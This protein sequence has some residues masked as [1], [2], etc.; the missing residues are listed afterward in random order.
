[1][2]RTTTPVASVATIL[3]A[4]LTVVA[5]LAV[6]VLLTP[7]AGLATHCYGAGGTSAA[8]TLCYDKKITGTTTDDTLNGTSGD[9]LWVGSDGDDTIYGKGGDD[10]IGRDVQELDWGYKPS[11]DPGADTYYGGDGED[12]LD[13][14]HDGYKDT[15]DCGA[16]GE[17]LASFEK[18]RA[19]SP[20]TTVSDNVNKKTCERLD[21]TDKEL[22]D[23][24]VKP[25]DNADVQCKTGTKRADELLGNNDPDILILDDMWGKGGN[26][27]LRG[28]RGFDG[29]E[30][31]PGDDTLYG[32]PGDDTLYGNE[33]ILTQGSS[34][35]KE[36]IQYSDKVY[37]GDGND[38]IDV[39][40]LHGSDPPAGS[41]P[42]PD[43]ISCGPGDHDWGLIDSGIDQDS[44]GVTLTR[45]HFDYSSSKPVLGKHGHSG[46]EFLAEDIDFRFWWGPRH[47]K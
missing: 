12:V 34:S 41:T 26:D 39:S 22:K 28:R 15:I 33:F 23:C 7:R 46:C 36:Y 40:D 43:T 35:D 20:K 29:L 5:F 6:L 42:K 14:N 3:L 11:D 44:Q 18:G 38:R 25:W 31:G 17:D 21:W 9:D 10:L 27:I 24:A 45:D 19:T 4:L 37:G 30:G 16:G 13:G 8:S 32:G 1:M 47:R 2:R